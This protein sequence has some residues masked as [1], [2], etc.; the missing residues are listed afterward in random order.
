LGPKI[1]RLPNDEL[2]GIESRVEELTNLLRFGSLNDVR[3]VG[4]SGMGGIGRQLL[5]GLYMK[6]FIINMIFIVL[7]MT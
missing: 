7:L 5:L 2:V 3:V 4:I 1:S 6:E